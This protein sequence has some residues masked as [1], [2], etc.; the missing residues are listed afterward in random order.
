MNTN[1]IQQ[2]PQKG[3]SP[4]WKRFWSQSLLDSYDSAGALWLAQ[5]QDAYIYL[6]KW[7]HYYEF[8]ERVQRGMQRDAAEGDHENCEDSPLYAVVELF[9]GKHDD[10]RLMLELSHLCDTERRLDAAVAEVRKAAHRY[11]EA[12][13]ANHR[14]VREE[15]YILDLATDIRRAGDIRPKGQVVD[16]TTGDR[17]DSYRERVWEQQE[18]MLCL[19]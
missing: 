14:A 15:L 8:S 4:V 16:A 13:C 19:V 12:A 7:A 3:K 9:F 18:L 2:T 5:L 11:L 10:L 1:T 6:Q 17:I